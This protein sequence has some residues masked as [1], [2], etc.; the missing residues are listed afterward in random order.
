MKKGISGEKKI[1]FFIKF[2]KEVSN[3]I[4]VLENIQLFNYR[5]DD[6]YTKVYDVDETNFDTKQNSLFYK[7]ANRY[8]S[9]AG[10][11]FSKTTKYYTRAEWKL[12]NL[13]NIQF[14][15]EEDD[16]YQLERMKP[17]SKKSKKNHRGKSKKEKLTPENIGKQK[18]KHLDK[19]KSGMTYEEF[20][21]KF[22]EFANDTVMQNGD[23]E[24][25]TYDTTAPAL[26]TGL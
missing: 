1:G 8:V 7:E 17:Q 15:S 23:I 16:N 19:D 10:A 18:P 24:D 14:A 12:Q 26:R 6:G 21:A 4:F 5:L 11:I 3:Q 20:V 22:P 25:F 2:N 13:R 9:A